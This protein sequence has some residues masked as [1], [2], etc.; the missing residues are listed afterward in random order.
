[1]GILFD[2]KRLDSI[3]QLLSR[4]IADLAG[5]VGK[6]SAKYPLL[7]QIGAENVPR[8]LAQGP[9]VVHLLV[10]LLND[11]TISF[12]AKKNLAMAAAY[13]V[14]P[15]DILPEGLIGP[16]GYLDD[17]LVAVYVFGLIINGGNIQDK[18][19]LTSLWKGEPADLEMLREKVLK[20]DAIKNAFNRFI[21]KK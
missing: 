6:Y 13:F 19:A 9:N 17:I 5:V 8:I 16:I 7:G 21:F 14:W 11:K 3:H 15:L 2:Q 10:S 20:L 4:P 18:A 1:M 12:E